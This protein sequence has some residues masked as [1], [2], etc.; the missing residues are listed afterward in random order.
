MASDG[1]EPEREL[2]DMSKYFIKIKGLPISGS[3]Q[4][5]NLIYDMRGQICCDGAVLPIIT[6]TNDLSSSTNSRILS[7][8]FITSFPLSENHLENRLLAV[9]KDQAS[10]ATY[11]CAFISMKCPRIYLEPSIISKSGAAVHYLSD[12]L[13]VAL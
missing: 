12:S 4:T 3:S 13:I 8:I 7:N 2:R 1:S 5:F 9:R 10:T 6:N 11:L